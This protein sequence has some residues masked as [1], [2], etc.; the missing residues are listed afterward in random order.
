MRPLTTK[1]ATALV[2][3]A[4]CAGATSCSSNK[5]VAT[6]DSPS[7]PGVSAVSSSG[8]SVSPSV[9]SPSSVPLSATPTPSPSPT[10][11]PDDANPPVPA[12]FRPASVTFV[13]TQTGF[14]LGTASCASGTCTTLVTTTDGGLHW[15]LVAT[16]P[17]R[18]T[19][20][21][22]PVNKVRF[23]NPR[24]GWLFGAELWATHDGGHSWKR[25][26]ASDPATEVEAS[27]GMAYALIGPRVLRAPVGSDTW[28]PVSS[29][30]VDT[31]SGSISLHGKAVWIV[32][33][34]TSSHL[35]QSADGTTWHDLGNPCASTGTNWNLAGAA[36]VATSSIYLL[37]IGDA[38]AGSQ[39]KK[40]LYSSD[41]G[42][43]VTATTA[44]PPRGG[45]AAGI[46]AA[47]TSVV[48]VAA[49]SGASEVYRSSNAGASWQVPLQHGDG[50]IG[51]F[52]LG[53]TTA[54][55]GV[56][57]YGQPGSGAPSQ[58]LMTHDAGATWA[59][60]AF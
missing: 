24:D 23:A 15:S 37:C 16:L 46:A 7:A 58:L 31:G 47:T 11:K 50:G 9:S 27:G 32:T 57:V 53:F 22:P 38:G 56:A 14:V 59:G 26:D 20:D 36:P 18:I 10:T 51:Y 43:H 41:A 44:D 35:I 13:S 54:T 3:L 45:D 40:V 4:T 12:G 25:I 48:A 29:L 19:G 1:L 21:E 52:D 34:G 30:S 39:S 2:A 28:S 33:G 60:V 17:Q 6:S 55:Q 42:A 8:V 5:H 49:R